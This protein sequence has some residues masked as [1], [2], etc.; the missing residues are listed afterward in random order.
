M[1]LLIFVLAFLL[2]RIVASHGE[3]CVSSIQ[4]MKD[5]AVAPV[6]KLTDDER[7]AVIKATASESRQ[8]GLLKDITQA[9]WTFVVNDDGKTV[10]KTEVVAVG[11]DAQGCYVINVHMS[12]DRLMSILK[13]DPT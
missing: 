3:T 4:D 6:V 8:E 1:K 10:D 11:F 13:G 9:Y 12:P 5:G 2:A 7:I